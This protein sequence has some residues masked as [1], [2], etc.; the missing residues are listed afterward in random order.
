[1]TTPIISVITVSP[2]SNAWATPRQASPNVI[3][4]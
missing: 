3:P 2:F 1:M 4:L